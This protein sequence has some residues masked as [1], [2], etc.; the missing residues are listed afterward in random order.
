MSTQAQT[1]VGRA[2]EEASATT[3]ERFAGLCAILAGIT[4]ILYSLT[5]VVIAPRMKDAGNGDLG[6]GLYSFFLMAGGFLTSAAIVGLY[7]RVRETDAYFALWGVILSLV[8]AV[9]AS[10]HGGYDLANAVNRPSMPNVDL[11]SQVDPRGM[12]TFGVAGL[13]LFVLSWLMSRSAGLPKGLAYL[14][15]VLSAFLVIVYLG[16]LIILDPSSYLILAPAALTGL[17]INPAWYIWLGLALRKR[18]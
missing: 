6:V 14:G 1:M 8:A 16:R 2:K 13:G 10:L 7:H 4:G 3:Y 12:L 9:G 11:P 18:S 15:L 5:F 17:I